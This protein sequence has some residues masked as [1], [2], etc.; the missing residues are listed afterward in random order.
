[1][2]FAREDLLLKHYDWNEAS[3]LFTGE[4]TRRVFNRYNGFQVLFI[5]N[6]CSA[7]LESFTIKEG[8][9]IEERIG[10]QLPLEIRNEISVFRWLRSGFFNEWML[11]MQK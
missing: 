2:S 10:N 6:C 9:D 7:F 8:R 4:P 3:A 5:I 11:K 1:M